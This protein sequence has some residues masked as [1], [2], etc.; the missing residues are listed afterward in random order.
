[1]NTKV[2]NTVLVVGASDKPDR[3]STRAIKMLQDANYNIIG[4]HPLLRVVEGVEVY[5]SLDQI[6]EVL[7]KTIDTVTIYVNTQVSDNMTES[8]KRLSPRRIIWNPGSENLS[9]IDN[10]KETSIQ[11]IEACTLVLLSTDQF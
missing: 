8:L 10:L 1:M 7:L 4:I 3:Y 11:N 6:P 9:V 2:K 5:P